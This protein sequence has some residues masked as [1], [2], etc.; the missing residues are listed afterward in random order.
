MQPAIVALF[1]GDCVRTNIITMTNQAW[2]KLQ[3]STQSG[4]LV[5]RSAVSTPAFAHTSVIIIC[6]AT[7]GP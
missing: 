1:S 7:Y 4:L 2:L 5:L 3:S 6:P